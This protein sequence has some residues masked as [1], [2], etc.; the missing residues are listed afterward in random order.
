M[1]GSLI[2]LP[3]PSTGEEWV[4]HVARLQVIKREN[5][6]DES[7]PRAIEYADRVIAELDELSRK[8]A[9]AAE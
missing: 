8:E 9:A 6:D 7:I 1:P 4:V 5:P 3:T 2:N